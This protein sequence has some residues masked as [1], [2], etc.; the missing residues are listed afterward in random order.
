MIGHLNWI[1]NISQSINGKVR[2]I[3]KTINYLKIK[4]QKAH[5]LVLHLYRWRVI[6]FKY[7]KLKVK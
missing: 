5:G 7:I 3:A 4:F 1:L 6:Y 2:V